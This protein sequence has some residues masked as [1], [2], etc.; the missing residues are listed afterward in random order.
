MDV[1][2]IQFLEEPLSGIGITIIEGSIALPDGGVKLFA[3]KIIAVKVAMI[4][5][6]V[7]VR[8]DVFVAQISSK[9]V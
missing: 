3:A 5:F 4:S 6:R 8:I 9:F 7:A 1:T 2:D